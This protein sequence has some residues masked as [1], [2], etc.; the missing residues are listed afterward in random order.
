MRTLRRSPPPPQHGGR[1]SRRRG[2]GAEPDRIS[3]LPDDMLLLVLERLQC[4]RTAVQTG[5][6]S[7][8]WRGLWTGLT[9]LAFCRL[10]PA[11]IE[12]LLARSPPSSVVVSLCD[13]AQHA[14]AQD[15]SLLRSAAAGLSPATEL[16][17]TVLEP[18]KNN[19]ANIELPCLP[20]TK[21][22]VLDTRNLCVKPPPAESGEF[23]ALE[24]LSISGR[25]VGLG[26]LLNRC[27]RLRFVSVR[28]AT[29]DTEVLRVT[30]PPAG[31]FTVL[32]ILSLTGRIYGLGA[33]L[34]RC[35]HLRVLSVNYMDSQ[36]LTLPS[37]SEFPALERL[38]LSGRIVGL[39]ASL[40][41]CPR[42]RFLSVKAPTLDEEQ[43]R[44]TPPP[45]GEFVPLESVSLAGRIDGLGSFLNRCRHLR[46]LSV[47]YMDSRQLTLP[48]EDE[49]PLLEK[50]SLSGNIADLG[51]SLNRC[52]R[53]RV[54]SVFFKGMTLESIEAALATLEELVPLGLV[55]SLLGIDD[56]PSRDSFDAA[57]FT[58]LLHAAAR[59]S[60]QEFAFKHFFDKHNSVHMPSF[61][62]T[63]SIAMD[64]NTSIR[65]RRIPEAAADFS[66]L[67]RLSLS[68]EYRP[69]NLATMIS[70]CQRLREL[71][72]T[73]TMGKIKV[74]SASLQKLY[75]TT[76]WDIDCLSIDI[77]A[78]MLKQL[79]LDVRDNGANKISVS[80]SA[81][82]VEQVSWKRFQVF[83]HSI[84]R[85]W[86]LRCLRLE[87][88]QDTGSV[89]CLHLNA[90]MLAS[91]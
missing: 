85:F 36:H 18:R 90:S 70:R 14:A 48:S 72:M 86:R 52:S 63:T 3:A 6:L 89:L 19:G 27:P 31:E 28:V 45:T 37:D 35:R 5:L 17:F 46:V 44:V 47:T 57:R 38:S 80:I 67:E 43:L 13:V 77:V 66:A 40:T 58:S 9:D 11:T 49:F 25:I 76:G 64:V 54:L 20:S 41:R 51:T 30:P 87:T 53:L 55:V 39:G 82:R 73:V 75:A 34:N 22:L 10:S 23:T 42:L 16:A 26:D 2:P 60:P 65:F 1:S 32:E 68:G 83:S 91:A 74:H 15:N 81:P 78:P 12:A 88:A 61:P 7:R 59:A 21:L 84:P 50:L 79:E 56:I 8:R 4:V 71:C 33:F 62:R 69:V 24:S 29:T